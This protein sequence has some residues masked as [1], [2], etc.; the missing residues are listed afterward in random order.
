MRK[1][2]R[3]VHRACCSHDM[4]DRECS[5]KK[6]LQNL[7]NHSNDCKLAVTTKRK[8]LRIQQYLKQSIR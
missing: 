8:L 7:G 6:V 1:L 4:R 3:R 2:W 5:S